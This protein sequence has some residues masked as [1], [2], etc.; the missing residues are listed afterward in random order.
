MNRNK[1]DYVFLLIE[2]S[3]GIIS[4]IT[5]LI[6]M[7][8][9]HPETMIITARNLS[10]ARQ[11]FLASCSH[12]DVV[13]VDGNLGACC[14][15]IET[16]PIVELIVEQRRQGKFFGKAIAISNSEEWN[17]MLLNAGCDE[18][19]GKIDIG[20]YISEGKLVKM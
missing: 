17:K 9:D 19:V 5:T 16:L 1:R 8:H 3:E 7:V 6:N 12:I 14:G 2:N 13:M 20:E 4:V 10:E 18:M 11:K 15:K